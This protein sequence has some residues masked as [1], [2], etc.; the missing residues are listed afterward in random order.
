M[1]MTRT[2]RWA[3]WVVLA[4]V[5]LA[6]PNCQIGYLAT[7][8]Y[9]Q[10]ELLAARVPVEEARA[11]EK[12]GEKQRKSLDTV[13]E[14]KK[15]AARIG[16]EGEDNYSTVALGWERQIWNV[17]ASDPVSFTPETWWFPI[18][19]TVPYLGYFSEDEARVKGRELHA[20]G[21]DVYVRSAATYSTLGWFEDPLLLPML[22][23]RESELANV[24][25]HELTHAT[26]WVPG[27]VAFNESL[28]SF[29]GDIA[30]LA[31][32]AE[33]Y[34]P[35][36]EQL[37]AALQEQED[38]ERWVAILWNLYRDLD[39]V[40]LDPTLNV[41]DKRLKKRELIAALPDRIEAAGFHKAR[42]YRI[43][44]ALGPW[45]NARLM[46]FKTYHNN[47]PWFSALLAREG[48][49]LRRFMDAIALL[50]ED[51]DEPEAALEAAGRAWLDEQGLAD[52][53]DPLE[54]FL[55]SLKQAP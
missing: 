20:G 39:A 47:R 11:S 34:G 36:S 12:L 48:G 44:A 25:L 22:S 19:G 6:L 5:L 52:P 21:R 35:D 42:P 51:A 31:W 26:V 18:V 45:N 54:T 8:G 49:D 38:D 41:A 40:Y 4:A 7:S 23:W 32:L 15:F 16:L 43:A 13:A 28:A 3:R 29:V 37:R 50:V 2:W 9:R 10:A 1:T 55:K 46:Q 33:T 17:S 53:P 27:G 14:V 30:S 24:V